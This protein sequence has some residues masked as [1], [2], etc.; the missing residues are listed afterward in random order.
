MNTA[1]KFSCIKIRV[2]SLYN[3]TPPPNTLTTNPMV[4]NFTI[5]VEASLLILWYTQFAC[6]LLD[7]IFMD[8]EKNHFLTIDLIPG[9]HKMHDLEIISLEILLSVP[10]LTMYLDCLL[11]VDVRWQNDIAHSLYMTSR[12]HPYS[13]T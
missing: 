11:H 10:I 5:S 7:K 13:N 12:A 6:S 3:C 2:Y 1:I 9:K 4:I 8:K